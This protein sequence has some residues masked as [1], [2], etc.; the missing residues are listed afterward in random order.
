MLEQF[1]ATIEMLY[2]AAAD[3]SLWQAALRAI[4][5]YTGSTGAVLNLV[6][7]TAA[8]LPVCLAGSFSDDDCAEYAA[9]YM[10]RCPRIAFAESHRDVSVHWDRL[11]LT[12]YEMDRDATYEWYGSHGL[13]YYVAGWVGGTETHHAYMSL[14]RS[15]RQGHVEPEDVEQ[16]QLVLKHMAQALA[17]AVRLGTLEQQCRFDL[18]LI[19]AMPQAVFAL[20]G[21]GKVV[22]AN[23]KAECLLSEGDAL[24][25]LDGKL[26]CRFGSDQ[27]RFESAVAAAVAADTVEH[28][29]GWVRIERSSGRRGLM[30]FI[31]PFISPECLIGATHPKVL[32]IIGDSADALAVDGQALHDLFGLTPA[33]S[34][35]ALT[36]S[37]GH[38]VESAAA[39]IGVQPATIRSELKSVFRKTSVNRQQDLVR[40]ITSLS[41]T[42]RVTAPGR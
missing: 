26:Q 7:K 3:P 5:D 10:W 34:R 40:L 13:R 21:A 6:P 41:L 20:D 15:R 42:P 31:A 25:V 12:E 23:A 38:S 1:S 27:S 11:I 24:A 8:A 4:E 22:M 36:L 39:L 14:Q 18:T 28:K 16:F 2:A 33:E 35:L 32:V 29:D 37:A 9:N 19:D 17:L 30:A